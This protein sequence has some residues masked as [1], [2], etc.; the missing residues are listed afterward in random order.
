ML[1]SAYLRISPA[2]NL[3]SGYFALMVLVMKSS[4]CL[5]TSVTSC[6]QLPLVGTAHIN[7]VDL[8][9]LRRILLHAA[10]L[11]VRDELARLNRQL[12]QVREAHLAGGVL[13]ELQDL[14]KVELVC[15]SDCCCRN[16]VELSSNK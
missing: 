2:H 13:G 1:M 15:H 14:V 5:S 12:A 10:L 9:V 8:L 11:P 3:W 7:R 16:V 6:C 4:T